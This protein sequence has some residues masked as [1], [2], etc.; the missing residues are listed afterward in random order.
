V[1]VPPTRW[2]RTELVTDCLRHT[3][4][5]VGEDDNTPLPSWT[6]APSE[7]MER[8]DRFPSKDR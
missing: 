1:L 6:L 4:A 2:L 8:M 7:R 5:W 3:T